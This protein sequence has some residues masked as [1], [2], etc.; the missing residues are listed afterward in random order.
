MLR[1]RSE[2]IIPFYAVCLIFINKP[3]NITDPVQVRRLH[4][5]VSDFESLPSSVGRFS[6]K[7]W[8]RDYEQFVRE[9]SGGDGTKEAEADLEA[10][11]GVTKPRNELRQFLEWPEFQF[12]KGFIR[13]EQTNS[14]DE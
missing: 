1:L 7:F 4:S 10:F 6:T 13:L 14:S 5:L 2:Y 12:W 8:L 9:N 11:E 3:G